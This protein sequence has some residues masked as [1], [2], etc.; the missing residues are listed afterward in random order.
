MV[1]H[2]AYDADN[3]H[4]AVLSVKVNGELVGCSATMLSDRIALSVARCFL[5]APTLTPTERA[6]CLR[7]ECGDVWVPSSAIRLVGSPDAR[8]GPVAARV[9]RMAFRLTAR[10]LVGDACDRAV[11]GEGWDIALLLLQPS[12]MLTPTVACTRPLVRFATAPPHAGLATRAVG[13]GS[14]PGYHR[15]DEWHLGLGDD[16]G[17]VRRAAPARVTA[18]VSSQLLHVATDAS[19]SA[20]GGVLCDGDVGAA[21]LTR[22]A[23]VADE[24]ADGAWELAG[25]GLPARDGANATG[26]GQHL[27][28]AWSVHVSRCWVEDVM[29]GWGLQPLDAG[30]VEECDGR[31]FFPPELAQSPIGATPSVVADAAAADPCAAV[32]CG[33]FGRCDGGECECEAAWVGPLCTVPAAPLPAAPRLDGTVVVA[34]DGSDTPTC[35]AH[36]EPCRTV[37]H[38]LL[39]QYWDAHHAGGGA[40]KASSV[41][42]LDGTFA[43]PGNAALILHGN[44][45]VIQSHS[46]PAD[47]TIDCSPTHERWGALISHG[48]T[49]L[50]HVRGLT[51]RKCIPESAAH[52]TLASHPAHAAEVAGALRWPESRRGAAYVGNVWLT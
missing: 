52:G 17:S 11:C 43:G 46:G 22:S 15:R 10:D 34:P 9:E 45:V 33:A 42:L 16:G 51:L 14:W 8:T 1:A 24:F 3:T 20:P 4:S 48:E 26:C 49:E 37:Q 7:G 50:A 5:A 27:S 38:A 28:Y 29:R 31:D 36:D 19:D 18:V 13:F 35:G 2:G 44:P 6:G 40:A 32:D 23:N 30:H 21:L 41:T 25:L 39:V 12:C 47:T